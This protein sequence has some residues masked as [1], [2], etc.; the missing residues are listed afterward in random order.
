MKR[1]FFLLLTMSITLHSVVA[2]NVTVN[3]NV[4]SKTMVLV[5]K[6]TNQNIN[7]GTPS[8]T[9]YSF[10]ADAGT[11]VLTGYASDG[12][13]VNGSIEIAI[14][15]EAEQTFKIF[16][17]TA[18]ATNSGWTMGSDYSVDCYVSSREGA[19]RTVTV[20]SSVAAGRM[21]FLLME[22]DTYVCNF[23]PSQDRADEGYI[24]G[25][26]SGTVNFNVNA[27]MAIPMSVDYSV[28][29]PEN[30]EFFLGTKASHYKA[31]SEVSPAAVSTQGG[32]KTI[33]YKLASGQTYNYRTWTTD[34]MTFA[35][36]FTANTDATKMPELLFTDTD[37]Q[38]ADPS[39]ISRDNLAQTGDILLNINE[40]GHLKMTTG[41]TYD[42]TAM[43]SWQAT[44]N[45]TGNYYM[46][47]RFRYT[48]LNEQG[49]PDNSVVT[50]ERYVTNADP[51][52]TLT[53]VGSGTA[54]VL[55]TYDAMNLTYYQNSTASSYMNGPFFGAIWPENTGVFV[56]TVDNNA[57]GI[58]PNMTIHDNLDYSQRTAGANV[59]AEHDVFYYPDT[60]QG[61]LYTFSPSGVSSV[62]MASPTISGTGATYTG[63]SS[64]GVTANADGSYTLLLR[65]GRNIVKMTDAAGH[66]VYQVL[67]AK[68]TV[69]TVSNT[70]R[71]GAA[72]YQP[73]DKVDVKFSTV[74]H[75]ANKLAGI[76]NMSATLTYGAPAT[77]TAS[78]AANQYAFAATPEAQTVSLTIPADEA[79]ET[80]TLQNG[81]IKVGGFGDPYG[82]HRLV[83]RTAGR[84]AN[85]TA[86]SRTAY[87][88]QLPDVSIAL[89][90]VAIELTINKNVADATITL[91][92]ADGNE[93]TANLDGTYTIKYGTYHYTALADGYKK[94]TGTIT[95]GEDCGSQ[96]EAAIVMEAIPANGW[97]GST[98]SE[99]QLAD[100][101]YQITNGAELAWFANEVTTNNNYTINARLL[102][103]IDLCNFAW[104]TTIGNNSSSTAF[105]GTLDGGGYTIKG[106]S[107]NATATYKALVG[108]AQGATVK[109]LTVEGTV[110]STA[111]YVAGIVAFA[112]GGTKIT[113]CVNRVVVSG[114]QYVGGITGYASNAIIERCGNE[115]DIT[116]S[117]SYVAG[118]TPYITNTSS[119]ILNCYN[120][121][122]IKGAGYVATIVANVYSVAIAVQN[123]LNVGQLVC[124]ATTTGNV[125]TGVAAR[126]AI[127]NNYVLCHY[128]NGNA[129]ETVVS[130][131]ELRDGTVAV[132]LGEAWGQDIGSDLYPVLGG[133]A[134]HNSDDGP[135][136]ISEYEIVTLTFEDEDYIGG[137]YFTGQPNWS[138]FID[139]PQYGGPLLYGESG[140]GYTSEDEAYNWA[141]LENTWL[142]NRLSE[143]YGMWSYWSGGHAL[144]NYGSG[145]IE[146]YGDFNSQLTVYHSGVSGLTR[147][148]NGHNG[149]DNFA[150]HYGYADNS[151]FGLGEES[152]PALT[153]ADGKARVVDH[154]Y[155][156]NTNYTLNCFL[157]GNGLTAKIGDNDWAKIV[158]TGYNDGFTTGTAEFYLCNG[159]A[160]IVRDWTKFDLSGLGEV[161]KITFNVLGS[162]DNGYG[163][164]QPAYFAYDD[165]AVREYTPCVIVYQGNA[166]VYSQR[167]ITFDGIQ[168]IDRKISG[169]DVFTIDFTQVTLDDGVKADNIEYLLFGNILAIVGD[170]TGLSGRNIVC[171]GQCSEVV[172]SDKW[173]FKPTAAFSAA[174]ATYTKTGL[175]GTG[176]YS[177]VLPYPFDLPAGVTAIGDATVSGNVITF[178]QL[179]G[180]IPAN[181]PFL[182]KTDDGSI[183]FAA[184]NVEVDAAATPASGALLGTYRNFYSGDA[185][186]K[187]ILNAEGSAF[188]TATATASI[189]AFRAYIES[190]S[191]GSGTYVIAIDDDV[192]GV[193]TVQDDASLDTTPVD[194][195]TI[196]GRRVRSNVDPVTA[197]QGLG[198]GTYII[199][200]KKIR[201]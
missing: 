25:T 11:Y 173:D 165:V 192:T 170:E 67:T 115:A 107:L 42:V 93:L 60:Q 22:G 141:D 88:G 74:Y 150:V 35:G 119:Q 110:T 23:I 65:Q 57:D 146:N 53:A 111:N 28:R 190:P 116:A 152:L 85:F 54:L 196:D 133:P 171:N 184:Q 6:A 78:G 94:T 46:E 135:V 5:N 44:D 147:T 129:Y 130:E 82:N 200:G 2:A 75:P 43:R 153:F 157:E 15:D 101:Y 58:T 102:N 112:A 137:T 167:D 168:A 34:G 177:C 26:V 3:M 169:R 76:Y 49:Q 41:D 151:G 128:N 21:T 29:V 144:S 19:V 155:V 10:E 197:L 189:P 64:D 160:N 125:Y 1:I 194:V 124:S 12:T 62:T 39:E 14:T 188:A 123:N 13:T 156:N 66:S 4:A 109:N 154:M 71:P 33:S 100:S 159:P 113:D 199:N 193:A 163:Y 68:P 17:V 175:D 40:R 178:A 132:A 136:N 145:D 89:T 122:I 183:T 48:V 77:P 187:L 84:N 114:K 176:W 180:T 185:T 134:V 105:K 90:R 131:A 91:T 32:S 121:A 16:T 72:T 191:A 47:P 7:V 182:Y 50:M 179:E 104:T 186:G 51:W 30:A 161:N 80:F 81:Y 59:D 108:Y 174:T 92:D 117:N 126:T 27:T 139:N 158:A 172:L 18:Y 9:T 36:Y 98:M 149:S 20:G 86:Q 69:V 37:Y 99:P 83:S 181:T 79:G 95:A 55:V 96:L 162:S 201:K 166:T 195:Y 87:F 61:A 63:F 106:F 103:D 45:T 31:F 38:T 118:I 52:S 148:G 70:S 143:G 140:F 198:H 120:T 97:D 56:V 138:S 24:T 8:G 164:S 73:G 142:S 127:A